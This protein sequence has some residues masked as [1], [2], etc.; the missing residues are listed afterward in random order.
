MSLAAPRAVI[1][2]QVSD[3]AA[4][5][6]AEVET[7]P[8]RPPGVGTSVPELNA[9][10][11]DPAS[12]AATRLEA[13]RR[14]VARQTAQARAA[15]RQAVAAADNPAARL[16]A[17]SALADDP[18]PE[19]ALVPEL[20]DLLNNENAAPLVRAAAEALAN[21][22]GNPEVL[23]GLT[24]AATRAQRN[25]AV[26]VPIITALGQLVEPAA[27]AALVRI[28]TDP[29][30]PRAVVEAAADAL[31]E[32]TAL[33]AIGRD[34][35]RWQQWLQQN[36]NLPEAQWRAAVQLA[37]SRRHD[38]QRR[39]AAALSNDLRDLLEVQYAASQN[40]AATLLRFLD[41]ATPEIRRA[42]ARLAGRVAKEVGQAV[43]TA[44]VQDRLLD[45][46]SDADPSVRREVAQTLY[47]VNIEPA[48][49]LPPLLAQLAVET[50]AEAT[51]HLIRRLLPV[52]TGGAL[53]RPEDL[54]A[55]IT[56][57]NARLDD[58]SPRVVREAAV[59][60][61]R[62]AQELLDRDR[63]LAADTAARLRATMTRLAR[64][65]AA[66]DIDARKAAGEA[67]APLRD[68]A[69][70]NFARDLL[71]ARPAEPPVIRGVA[72]HILGE[73][74]GADASETI[75]ARIDAE[76]TDAFVRS[77]GMKA[78]ART[79][80]FDRNAEWLVGRMDPSV[81]R[82]AAVR[83]AADK[84]YKDLVP[85]GSKQKLAAEA[86]ARRARQLLR[87]ELLKAL[88]KK[89]TAD[90]ELREAAVHQQTLGGD[91]LLRALGRPGE[92]VEPLM[93]A[94]DY[95]RRQNAPPEVTGRLLND[96]MDA[97]IASRRYG[98]LAMLGTD[99]IGAAR[100]Q[101]VSHYH[102]EFGSK[103]STGAA[104]LRDAG[105]FEDSSALID[106]AL[107]M[108]PPLAPRYVRELTAIRKSVDELR[109]TRNGPA[110]GR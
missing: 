25:A 102:Q 60:I 52:R 37:R 21:Y 33:E 107:K 104:R 99:M 61:G 55:L 51:V 66:D 31:V 59:G 43:I 63:Q 101:D 73:L 54:R 62:R 28:A 16:A 74:G 36:G 39:E 1:A 13:A 30:A 87:A 97:L 42:G 56:S 38:R 94:M 68:K 50:D 108:D 76:R 58:P 69:S 105:K 11:T 70:M 71:N 9:T 47:D 57:L 65:T 98:E 77:E 110:A 86:Q 2:L 100:P 67:L 92:A 12:S 88:I 93:A 95:W 78:L 4:D 44:E 84:A 17:V 45:L 89:H 46:V 18:A 6:P 90:G 81:E 109:A 48:R 96:L 53:Q 15:L 103:I 27:A 23:A 19:A 20:L 79:R 106:T 75:Q 24:T 40:K 3:D 32:M 14:L 49:A 41:M 82:A 7:E 64:R 72:L 34:P 91:V 5:A 85:T 26:R 10:L 80:D 8:A 22:K 35:A 29:A 83:E